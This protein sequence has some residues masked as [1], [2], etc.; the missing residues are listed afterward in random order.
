MTADVLTGLG[1]SNLALGRL[2]QAEDQLRAA[3]E[4]DP[5]SIPAWNNLGVLLIEKGE[6]GAAR[7]VFQHVLTLDGGDL[8]EIRGNLELA[9]ARSEKS[10]Y[11]GAEAGEFVLI[12]KGG[13]TYRLAPAADDPRG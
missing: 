6:P 9:I 7:G 10:A 2:G 4:R 5:A 8:P 11:T 13:G 3:T 1:S 12:R